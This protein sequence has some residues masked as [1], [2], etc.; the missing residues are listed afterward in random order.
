MKGSMEEQEMSLLEPHMKDCLKHI[1]GRLPLLLFKL[2]IVCF[3]H[4][5]GLKS[6]YLKLLH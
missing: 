6:F 2:E 3:V 1:F 4:V 5:L